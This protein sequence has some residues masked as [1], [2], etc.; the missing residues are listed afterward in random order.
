MLVLA[1]VINREIGVWESDLST[2]VR[3]KY[4][5]TMPPGVSSVIEMF[6]LPAWKGITDFVN[7]E[8]VL[9]AIQPVSPVPA[10]AP[11]S[12]PSGGIDSN[13]RPA[14]PCFIFLQHGYCRVKRCRY[15]HDLADL[16]APVAG[17]TGN[18]HHGSA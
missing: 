14:G 6:P 7:R 16:A 11:S 9:L 13:K 12:T 3:D 8:G 5:G 18:N 15:R 17:S 2:F 4:S 1:V 10:P